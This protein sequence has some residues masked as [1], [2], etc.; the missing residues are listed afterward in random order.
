MINELNFLDT[1]NKPI[2]FVD[3]LT[4][5]ARHVVSDFAWGGQMPSPSIIEFLNVLFFE[6]VN[7]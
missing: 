5:L 3:I 4:V 7:V 6:F 1:L 2:G